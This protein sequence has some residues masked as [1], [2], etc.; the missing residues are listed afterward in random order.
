MTCIVAIRDRKKFYIGA[1]SLITDNRTKRTM[2]EKKILK[3]K[4]SNSLI[5]I[6]GDL[7]LINT[8][9]YVEDFYNEQ[10]INE[11]VLYKLS[12]KLIEKFIELNGKS[13]EILQGHVLLINKE[14]IYEIA[15]YGEVMSYNDDFFAIGIGDH[16]A[17]G[18]LYSTAKTKMKIV[19]R[20]VLAL[21]CAETYCVGVQ[22]P[23]YIMN[24]F[25]N[26]VL[27]VK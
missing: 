4:N 12:Q 3:L 25:N 8:I 13:D 18:S 17:L 22:R 6:C 2:S 21:E 5:G 10:K 7:R 9:H 20:I 19:D 27:E 14:K 11:D 15:G 23:F 26:D 1:D 16:C 24:N